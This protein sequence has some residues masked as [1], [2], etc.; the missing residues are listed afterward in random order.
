MECKIT[1]DSII[2][3]EIIFEG[4]TEQPVDIDFTLPDYCPDIGKILKCRATPVVQSRD[5]RR[6]ALMI[7]GITHLEVV[8]LD[9][10]DKKVRC[11][12][13]DVPFS[14]KF[15]LSDC[16]ETAKA[17]VCVR[18][19]YMNCRAM[20]QRRVDIHGA[21]TL[22]ASVESPKKFDLVSQ[23]EG[24]GIRTRKCTAEVSEL[25]GRT[26]NTFTISEALDLAGGMLPISSIVRSCVSI[27]LHEC[28]PIANKLILKG[29]ALLNIVYC[30]DSGQSLE[31]MEYSLPFN[32]FLDI[33]GV[34]DSCLCD[35]RLE[36][37]AKDIALRTDYDGEYRRLSVDIRVFADIKAYRSADISLI[38]D[39]YSTECELNTERRA[40]FF[41]RFCS[42]LDTKCMAN[43]SVTATRE[44]SEVLDTWCEI[45]SVSS[46]CK[47][48]RIVTRGTATVCTIVRYE[49]GD[50]DYLESS[51]DFE[52]DTAPALSGDSPRVQPQAFVSGCTYT[53]SGSTR[54]DVRAEIGITACVCED[55]HL[56]A[57][58]SIAPDESRIKNLSD[59]PSVVMYFAEKDEE[60]WCIARE[61]NSSVEDIMLDNGISTDKL[62]Q[63]ALLLITVR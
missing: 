26:Q 40:M 44:I 54:I 34:D 58:S 33:A 63:P 47:D 49:D 35:A 6:D 27:S 48:S 7:E 4:T 36:V 55:I 50:C 24:A 30:T 14:A 29:E 13:H 25:V 21:F 42:T 39:A 52:C 23:A 57:L 46:I 11:C 15:A 16:P 3:P 19:D 61:H 60:L 51:C 28:K 31:K 12:E 41:E 17:S 45:A 20:S 37:A 53:L 22:K 32:Q 1:G 59:A 8:Y 18:V 43:T 9:G 2:T 56:S 5:V 10:R 62:E 38:C